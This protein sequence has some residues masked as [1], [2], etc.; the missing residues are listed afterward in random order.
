MEM[1]TI[2][3]LLKAILITIGLLA[4]LPAHS[5]D[6]LV[7]RNGEEIEVSVIDISSKTVTYK[8]AY[9]SNNQLFNIDKAKLFMIKW[10][11][12]EKSVFEKQEAE[13]IKEKAVTVAEPENVQEP[14]KPKATKP[15]STGTDPYF[16]D[17]RNKYF[18][19]AVGYGNSYGGA[20][21]RLQG[22]FGGTMGFG[23]H[24]GVG[25]FP[26][27]LGD[28]VMYSAGLKYFFY[29]SIYLNAQYGIF[30]KSVYVESYYYWDSYGNYSYDYSVEDG[31]LFGPS[32]IAGGDWIWGKHFGLNAAA[33]VSYNVGDSR[34]GTLFP[35]IDLGF[36][37]KF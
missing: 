3:I 17:R 4:L 5:Q 35:A 28:I 24:G 29:R 32:L 22:R 11:N 21:V 2:N 1:K 19:I 7:L 9:S 26:S 25:Y 30:G 12:G 36:I 6:I 8:M 27:D 13:Y 10:E 16:T 15:K 31:I 20:G 33:G 14:V 37:I 18:S 34:M 23:L